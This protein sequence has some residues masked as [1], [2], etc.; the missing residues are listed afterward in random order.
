MRHHYDPASLQPQHSNTL[1]KPNEMRPVYAIAALLVPSA[2]ADLLL[3]PSVSTGQSPRHADCK[4]ISNRC[5]TITPS[6]GHVVRAITDDVKAKLSDTAVFKSGQHIACFQHAFG[7]N[8]NCLF[9]E[10][11]PKGTRITG[12][13]VKELVGAM[14]EELITSPAGCGWDGRVHCGRFWKE[15]WPP[16]AVLK[17]DYVTNSCEGIC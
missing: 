6:V 10:N 9:L 13:E 15:T 1:F 16:G 4:N 12:A 8:G 17:I 14:W 2:S 11:W 5:H 7:P 3:V